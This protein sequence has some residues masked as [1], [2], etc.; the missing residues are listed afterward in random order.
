MASKWNTLI[1][2]RADLKA[3]G[4]ALLAKTERSA[5]D[6]TEL[7]QIAGKLETLNADIEREEKIRE[8]LRSEGGVAYA[9]PRTSPAAFL[10]FGEQLGAVKRFY[11]SHGQ[12]VDNRLFATSGAVESVGSDGGFLLQPTFSS[13][14]LLPLHETGPFSSRARP[15]PVGANSNSGTIFGVDET[16]RATGSRWGGIRG[17]RVAEAGTLTPSRPKFRKI[18]WALK[19]YAVLF[20]ATDELL[21]DSTQ[22]EAIAR[23]GSGEELS[24]M[25]NDDIMNGDGAGGAQGFMSSGALVTV[26]KEAGQDAATIVYENLTKMWARLPARSKT[27]AAWYINTDCNPALDLIVQNVG[28]GGVPANFVTYGPDSVMR[29]KGRPVVETEYNETLGSLGDIVLGDMSEYLFWERGP[30]EQA[31]S[32]HVEFLTDQTVFRF[33]YRADGQLSVAKALT[34]YKGSN[35]QSPIVALAERA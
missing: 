31:S 27:S 19:K 25:V 35:K 11:T 1:Q 5:E 21:A 24:F 6:E 30:V 9:Q 26:A 33:I 13:V 2:E 29:I 23:Q 8:A 3:K 32:I 15:L 12:E 20:Y 14:I 18:N 34:P 28:L 17:Y 16:D 7:T 4:N 22:L 10:S